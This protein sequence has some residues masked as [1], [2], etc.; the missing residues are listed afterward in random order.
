MLNQKHFVGTGFLRRF[1]PA[2]S[3]D[4][5]DVLVCVAMILLSFKAFSGQKPISESCLVM[6]IAGQALSGA[7]SHS[8]FSNLPWYMVGP[9]A[10]FSAEVKSVLLWLSTPVMTTWEFAARAAGF[11]PM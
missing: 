2:V 6:H 3:V 1:T 9:S 11:S 5:E 8:A 7:N 4:N 10:D